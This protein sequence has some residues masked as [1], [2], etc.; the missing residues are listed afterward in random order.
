VLLG[1]PPAR[2]FILS[3]LVFFAGLVDALA[4]GGGLI[5]LPAY[6]AAGLNPLVL[7]G[8]NKLS[9]SI[10]TAAAC[11]NY[12]RGHKLHLPHLG[13]PIAAALLGSFF[14]ARLSSLLNPNW[15]KYILLA[16]I[17]AV[18]A[19]VYSKHSF[20]REDRSAGLGG[21]E[22]GRRTILVSL[23]VGGYDGFIG[24][25]AGTFL[26][27]GLSRWCRY[28][29]LGSTAR[30]KFL[31]LATNLAA[32]TFFLFMGRVQLQLGLAMGAI[33]VCGNWAGA[34]LGLKRGASAI[35]PAVILVCA[36]LF[37]KLAWDC[38]H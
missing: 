14:G 31:N 11:V 38:L 25:G 13:W 35:R 15:F 5:T 36:G 19:V 34:H 20:G 2:F 30:A 12:Q 29:L 1:F 28:D 8:T 37:A 10:G 17:P 22:L 18:G 32:L 4:G 23:S 33:S 9:S 21:T 24:P 3:A 26:A 6:L 7:L 27:L 16:V